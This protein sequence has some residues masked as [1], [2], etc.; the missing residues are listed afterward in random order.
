MLVSV[1]EWPSVF[2]VPDGYPEEIYSSRALSL[3]QNLFI[4]GEILLTREMN[5]EVRRMFRSWESV[6]GDGALRLWNELDAM[7]RLVEVRAP[8]GVKATSPCC[9]VSGAVTQAH[10]PVFAIAPS[11][12]I[13][14]TDCTCAVVGDG[15][16]VVRAESIA[17]SDLPGSLLPREK[18]A[19]VRKVDSDEEM[20]FLNEV[21]IPFLRNATDISIYDRILGR[22]F[23]EAIDR[24]EAS[25]PDRVI[26]YL[27]R[28][29]ERAGSGFLKMGSG[30]RASDNFKRSVE[31]FVSLAI[32]YG[33]KLERVTFKTELAHRENNR[34]VSRNTMEAAAWRLHAVIG[35]IRLKQA[36]HFNL[37]I[38]MRPRNGGA[39]LEDHERYFSSNQ[40]T[41]NVSKGI[42]WFKRVDDEY[43]LDDTSVSFTGLRSPGEAFEIP[44]DRNVSWDKLVRGDARF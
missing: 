39:L 27:E 34:M 1:V 36:P 13:C 28:N 22:T 20:S 41:L 15:L 24:L 31:Y 14:G 2:H 37:D 40:I 26:E 8:F 38:E 42:S 32:K 35:S 6:T 43:V 18:S 33:S 11:N 44:N 25:R 4:R 30:E 23:V 21:W 7:G 12:C 17:F 9:Q 19:G 10:R 16:K 3:I 29:H 5:M